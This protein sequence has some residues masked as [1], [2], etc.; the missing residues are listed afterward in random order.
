MH[1]SWDMVCDRWPERWTDRRMDGRTGRRVDGRT[2]GWKDRRMDR[3][4]DGKSDIE[5][6]HKFLPNIY[7]LYTLSGPVLHIR[8]MGAIF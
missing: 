2:D 3:Q 6:G 8:G 1:G 4:M 7:I 5:V